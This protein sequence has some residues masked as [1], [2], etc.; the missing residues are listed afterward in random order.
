MTYRIRIVPTDGT[1]TRKEGLPDPRYPFHALVERD[2]VVVGAEGSRTEEE[3]NDALG[4]AVRHA[5]ARM[6]K[7]RKL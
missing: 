7:G 4:D 5:R 3:C 2:G 6:K 1:L